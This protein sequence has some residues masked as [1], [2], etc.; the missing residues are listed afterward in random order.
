MRTT[1]IL[2]LVGPSHAEELIQNMPT[3]VVASSELSYL[4][5]K[6]QSAFM[7]SCLR[8]YTSQDLVGV[9]LGGALKNIFAIAAGAID[10]L[11]LGDNTKAALNDER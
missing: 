11:G 6:V 3:A 7:N 4:A 5:K 10:G 2:Y 9:E 1:L 8:V